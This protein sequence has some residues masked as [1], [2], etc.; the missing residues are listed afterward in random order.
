MNV[1]GHHSIQEHPII[2]SLKSRYDKSYPINKITLNHLIIV[3]IVAL[4]LV[5]IFTKS[6]ATL[7]D[8]E[9]KKLFNVT[10]FY[11]IT[12][13]KIRQEESKLV[14][15]NR[16]WKEEKINALTLAAVAKGDFTKHSDP[17]ERPLILYAY[18]E[19]N[20][21]RANLQYFIQHG[22][23][24]GAD[25][26]FVI[27]GNATLDLLLPD[28]IPN[29]RI[30]RRGND[31]FDLGGIG[32]VLNANDSALV[33]RYSKFILMNASVRGPFMPTWAKGCWSD[34]F[35]NKLSDEVKLVGSTYNC[36]P[37]GHIQSMVFATDRIG[38]NIL[39]NGNI[40]HDQDPNFLGGLSSCVKNKDDA[41][42]I[43]ISLTNLI[44]RAQYKVKVLQARAAQSE[45]YYDDCKE[46]GW[47]GV[48]AYETI[49][50]KTNSNYNIEFDNTNFLTEMH[51][52]WGYSSWEACAAN[53]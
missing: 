37:L 52:S 1:H 5:L 14:R 32:E 11:E 28:T 18:A 20:F 8:E 21:A 12:M 31:C 13:R 36:A 24:A 26:I 10:E 45:T 40:T 47:Q 16:K 35:L 49:F 53:K 15:V 19:S 50:V 43:E 30:I 39:L 51:D 44:H 38:M 27:N 6:K 3:I 33:K 48:Q 17:S 7:D 34:M 29:V 9:M 42:S 46:G 22:L 41:I 25:F 2:T 23:Y 4:L